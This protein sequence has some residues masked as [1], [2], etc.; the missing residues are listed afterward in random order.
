GSR[1]MSISG[2][3]R[4]LILA[5]IFGIF[6][7][8]GFLLFGPHGAKTEPANLLPEAGSASSVVSSGA[9]GGGAG[10]SSTATPDPSTPTAG[11]FIG[12]D[13]TSPDVA[14]PMGP[15]EPT[16]VVPDSSAPATAI[17]LGTPTPLALSEQGGSSDVTAIGPDDTGS[18]D[19]SSGSGSF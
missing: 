9:G 14:I 10:P 3:F 11:G 19:S 1:A 18:S 7:V 8:I 6:I 16:D 2:L 13:V 17:S 15:V 5:E 12:S 4:S